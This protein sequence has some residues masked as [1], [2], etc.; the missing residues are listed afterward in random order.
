[1]ADEMTEAGWRAERPREE[2]YYWWRKD[3]ELEVLQVW[4]CGGLQV[5]QMQTDE[6]FGS[7]PLDRFAREYGGEWLGPITPDSYQQGRVASCEWKYDDMDDY[8]ETACKNAYCLADGTLKDNEHKYCPYC[9]GLI[10]LAQQA[11]EGK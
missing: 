6:G 1:M 5:S 2:G 7:M 9:G 11:Q 10:Q 4:D 8:Y 3:H